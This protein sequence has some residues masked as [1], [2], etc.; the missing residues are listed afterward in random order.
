MSSR[1]STPSLTGSR[2][3]AR[4][5]GRS[6]SNQPPSV[7]SSLLLAADDEDRGE[8]SAVGE[9]LSE[10]E[11]LPDDGSVAAAPAGNRQL[12]QGYPL[13][14]HRR[15]E[16]SIG[17]YGPLGTSYGSS[18]GGGG[19]TLPRRRRGD[20]NLTRASTIT[21]ADSHGTLRSIQRFSDA[22]RTNGNIPPPPSEAPPA[23]PLSGSLMSNMEM[24]GGGNGGG[25][26]GHVINQFAMPT[27]DQRQASVLAAMNAQAQLLSNMNNGNPTYIVHRKCVCVCV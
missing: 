10:S 9:D 2:K 15:R 11:L 22:T 23:T 21:G 3:R 14:Q 4:T 13:P 7:T 18:V 12:W 27:P 19:G 5:D 16:S 17:V 26:G 1:V 25:G 6:A 24:S 20:S 8:N